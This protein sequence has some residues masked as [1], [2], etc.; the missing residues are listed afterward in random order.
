MMQTVWNYVRKWV[1][2]WYYR[3][4]RGPVTR[5]FAAGLT[6]VVGFGLLAALATTPD[7]SALYLETDSDTVVVGEP[8]FID[9]MVDASTAVNAVDVDISFPSELLSITAL[10]EGESVLTI[11]TEPPSVDGDIITISGGTFRRGFSGEHRILSITAVATE[12]GVV[13]LEPQSVTLLA[14]DGSGD[15]VAIT[16]SEQNPLR[17]Y[18]LAPGERR[19]DRTEAGNGLGN[20]R[21]THLTGQGRVTMQDISVFMSAWN[22]QAPTYDFTGDGLMTFRDFSILLGDFFMGR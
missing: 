3:P 14:G 5:T 16:A 2:P 19:S 9:V 17:L 21:P 22:N 12:P 6:A 4:Q 18:A 13:R 15:D 10:R 1:W 20:P 7:E 8:F 11:W